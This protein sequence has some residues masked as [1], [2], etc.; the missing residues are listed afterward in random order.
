MN[1]QVFA[2]AKIDDDDARK[3]VYEEIKRGRSRF[4]MWDQEV[5]LN[6]QYHGKNGFLL[7]IQKG[8]WI[9]HVNSPHYGRCVAV[10]A[11]GE[12]DF[13]EGIECSW[14]RDFCNFIPVDTSSFVEFDRTDP[15]IIPSVNLAPMRR[16]Q[17]VLQAEDF[18]RSLD[19]LRSKKFSEEKIEL[20]GL[21]H[22]R[23]KVQ[24]ELLPRIT[25]LIHQMNKS[26]EFERFLHSIFKRMPNTVSI[27]NGF[28]WRTDHGA[29]LIVEF[30]NPI[31]G[32]N[33][34]SKLVVQA[35]SYE[36]G[37]YELNAVDQI[38]EA[39]KQYQADGGLLITTAHKTEQLE[40][41]LRKTSDETG[42]AIDLIA[43]VDVARFVIR[44][45]PEMLVGID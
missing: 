4:G 11:V 35:K 1:T 7:R 40:D 26:K 9:V 18:L 38:V 41:Y 44:Y 34:T 14:G 39:I 5:S 37:H 8:D 6:E 25:E 19:N 16:G 22:L 24:E 13:D 10:R 30:Q 27:Q 2:F 20:R 17:R 33:L 31:I 45:A 28:G 36:G 43:G 12:Y 23:E 3:K 29:D 21:L 42:K 15:N 32:V